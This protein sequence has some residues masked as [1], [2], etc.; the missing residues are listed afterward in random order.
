MVD[1]YIDRE[2]TKYDDD[3]SSIRDTTST[4]KGKLTYWLEGE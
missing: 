3:S 1:R 2:R 4:N